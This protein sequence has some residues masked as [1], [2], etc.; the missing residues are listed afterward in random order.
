MKHHLRP[1]TGWTPLTDTMDKQ[2]NKQQQK[3]TCIF[4][5]LVCVLDRV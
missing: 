3:R 5:P 1:P 2:K 4:V